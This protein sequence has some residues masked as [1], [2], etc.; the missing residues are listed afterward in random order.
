VGSGWRKI[1]EIP[2][3]P[4]YKSC[5]SSGMPA[6]CCLFAGLKA[7]FPEEKHFSLLFSRRASQNQNKRS[8]QEI[9]EHEN[10]DRIKFKIIRSKLEKEALKPQHSKSAL[11]LVY[12]F[13]IISPLTL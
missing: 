2:F 8:K 10:K 1:T 13:G 6:C 11:E 5:P 4:L 12:L 7:A 3:T 9:K